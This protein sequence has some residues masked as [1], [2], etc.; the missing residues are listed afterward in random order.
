MWIEAAEEPLATM[1][2]R[3]LLAVNDTVT[4]GHVQVNGFNTLCPAGTVAR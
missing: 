3:S 2:F 4:G 1:K